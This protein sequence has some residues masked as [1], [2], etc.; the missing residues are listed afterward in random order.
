MG[1]PPGNDR[2]DR[3]ALLRLAA[4]DRDALGELY[5]RHA[6]PLYRH[7]VWLLGS[8]EDAQDVV[9]SV[10]VKLTAM[11]PNVRRIQKL[12]V[13]L[14]GMG[15]HEG[16]DLLRRRATRREQPLDEPLFEARG[17]DTG[18]GAER[19][20]LERLLGRLGAAQREVV[21]LHLFEGHSFREIGQVTGVSL[22]TAASR[23]RLAMKRLRQEARGDE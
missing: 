18:L 17:G 3:E 2:D 5:D 20:E 14:A 7:A 13:Y 12:R 21:Y 1:E 6:E 22:F 23:F 4:G 16:L 19:C 15:H 9:Q 10:F 11:G 8:T